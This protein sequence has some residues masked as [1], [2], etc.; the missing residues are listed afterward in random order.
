MQAY[1]NLIPAF[2][3]ISDKNTPI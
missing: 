2:L 3:S 1:K